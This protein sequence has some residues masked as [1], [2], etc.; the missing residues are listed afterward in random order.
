MI[1]KPRTFL[2]LSAIGMLVFIPFALPAFLFSLKVNSLWEDGL[3]EVAQR[4]SKLS[5]L[6][7]ILTY[8][9]PPLIYGIIVWIASI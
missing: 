1:K 2:V 4:Y 8:V 6:F 9:L 3:V 7:V 5:L